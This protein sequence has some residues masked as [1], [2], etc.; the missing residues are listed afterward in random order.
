[1]KSEFCLETTNT[2]TFRTQLSH[3]CGQ[4][5]RCVLGAELLL[6]SVHLCALFRFAVLVFFFPVC[7]SVFGLSSFFFVRVCVYI[8]TRIII[9]SVILIRVCDGFRL[10]RW[11]VVVV[12][13]ALID[14][15]ALT[16]CDSE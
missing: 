10:L 5:H 9:I 15:V 6:Q 12:V 8:I 1:V 13:V 11:C 2:P 7:R 16:L 4:Q 14:A 3:H